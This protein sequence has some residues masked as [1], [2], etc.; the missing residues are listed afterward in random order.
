MK[1]QLEKELKDLQEARKNNLLTVN[2]YC[3]IYYA[4]SQKIKNLS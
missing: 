2:E 1:A 3:D 4:I